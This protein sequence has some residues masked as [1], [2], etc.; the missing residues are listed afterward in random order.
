MFK[1]QSKFIQFFF[2]LHLFIAS[3][4]LNAQAPRLN[5]SYRGIASIWSASFGTAT[6]GDI[7]V[8]GHGMG[9]RTLDMRLDESGDEIWSVSYPGT[10]G[11]GEV[12]G[13]VQDGADIYM[14][15]RVINIFDMIFVKAD[16]SNGNASIVK[17]FTPN[18][19]GLNDEFRIF[20][21][22]LKSLNYFKIYNR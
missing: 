8:G 18:N 10:S 21:N 22:G 20:Q 13:I 3:N 19:D 2:I 11:V 15:G 9:G 14:C 7:L 1:S 6:N 16:A 5:K 12:Y 17:S 4:V